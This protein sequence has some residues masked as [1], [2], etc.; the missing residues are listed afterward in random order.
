MK[1][2]PF[3]ALLIPGWTLGNMLHVPHSPWSSPPAGSAA[4][5]GCWKR[6]AWS[7]EESKDSDTPVWPRA[8]SFP[9]L[10]QFLHLQDGVCDL[11]RSGSH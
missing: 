5:A 11:E 9:A 7:L 8:S 3:F 6:E 4:G 10:I 1:K 2:L